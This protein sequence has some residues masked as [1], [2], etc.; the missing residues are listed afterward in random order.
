MG[1][2]VGSGNS[3]GR[4]LQGKFQTVERP[5]LQFRVAGRKK[6]PFEKV[7]LCKDQLYQT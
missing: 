6:N 4:G 3:K 2:Y 5:D 1:E 7:T